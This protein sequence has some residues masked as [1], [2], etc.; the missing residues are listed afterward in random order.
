[1]SKQGRKNTITIIATVIILGQSMAFTMGMIQ[2]HIEKECRA[3]S[4]LGYVFISNKLGCELAR[5]RFNLK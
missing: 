1:M 3:Q 2:G 4:V 5:P